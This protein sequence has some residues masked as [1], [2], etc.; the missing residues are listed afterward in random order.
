MP[1][2]FSR[3]LSG[4][5]AAFACCATLPALA[6]SVPAIEQDVLPEP[7]ITPAAPVAVPAPAPRPPE[8]PTEPPGA[9]V[10]RSAT[11][12]V[13]QVDGLGIVDLSSPAPEERHPEPLPEAPAIRLDAGF[14]FST[15]SGGSTTRR[16]AGDGEVE[17]RYTRTEIAGA[18]RFNREYVRVAGGG[19]SVDGDEYDGN[20]AWRT[21]LSDNPFYGFISPRS[22][23]NRYGYFRSSQSLRIGLGRRWEPQPGNSYTLEAGPGLRWARQQNGD[24]V[25]EGLYTLSAKVDLAVSESLG[26]KF[27]VVDERSTR[28]NYR[29]LATSLRSRLTERVWIKLEYAFRRAF[30]FDAAPSSAETSLDAG[31]TYRF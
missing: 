8:P 7:V 20:V 15:T 10:V 19:S 9:P 2:L 28:E 5:C 26:F 16:Y 24:N 27:S 13:R 22:R 21:W 1:D 14:T 12:P 11:K 30:P 31:L 6:Q 29:T 18:L 3:R 23:Y 17:Y 25:T 4:L